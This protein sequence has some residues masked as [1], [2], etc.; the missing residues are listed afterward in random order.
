MIW[1]TLNARLISHWYRVSA[2]WSN[3]QFSTKDTL[4]G[5]GPHN[6]AY[7]SIYLRKDNQQ[8]FATKS[9]QWSPGDKP[10]L[11]CSPRCAWDTDR[12]GVGCMSGPA[13]PGMRGERCY[14]LHFISGLEQ[15]WHHWHQQNMQQANVLNLNVH[16][17]WCFQVSWFTRVWLMTIVIASRN[18]YNP[19]RSNLPMIRK[20]PKDPRTIQSPQTVM[21]LKQRPAPKM[22]QFGWSTKLSF[23]FP[24]FAVA[25]FDANI[26]KR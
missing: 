19:T 13:E 25:K 5:K 12:L 15:K 4:R 20:H 24:R 3:Q 14:P 26:L 7:T 23:S 21:L 18:T 16:K 22:Q 17:T 8:Y 10:T 11:G 6:F 2:T 9:T 1:K